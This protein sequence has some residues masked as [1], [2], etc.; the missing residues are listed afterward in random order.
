MGSLRV[1]VSSTAFDLEAER[2]AVKAALER[3]RGTEFSGMELFGSRDEDARTA[4]LEEVDDSHLYVGIIGGRYGSGI[5]R[6]EYD[7]ARERGL[8]CLLYLQNDA[9]IKLRDDDAAKARSREEWIAAITD[10]FNGHLVPRFSSAD[11]LA[12]MVAADVHNWLFRTLV[13]ETKTAA[14]AGATAALR[15]LLV[16]TNNAAALRAALLADGVA[17]GDDLL[18][19]L[20]AL[21]PGTV[22]QLLAGIRDLP[23][24]YAARIENF[25]N[26]YIGT[27]EQPVP[28]GG[29]ADV[30]EELDA[31]LDRDPAHPYLLIAAEAGRGK[32]AALVHWTRRRL[33]EPGLEVVFV[34]VSIRFRT[35]L[36][37]VFFPAL[38]A[39]LARAHGDEV[40]TDMNLPAEVWRGMV[41]DYLREPLPDGRMLV[42]V[43]DG[44]DEAADWEAGADLFP[45]RAPAG[46]RIVVSARL[47]ADL[48]SDAA[49][50]DQLGWDTHST[51]T[52]ALRALT[53]EGVGDVMNGMG[54]P[55]ADLGE[56]IVAA[57]YRLSEGDPLLIRLYVAELW[58]RGDEAGRLK[59]EDLPAIDPGL[60]GFFDRWWR[61]QKKLWGDASP[62]KERGVRTVLNL[63]V[64]AFGPLRREDILAL[65]P[66]ESE[67]T[68]WTL[69]D[70]IEPVRRF[71]IEGSSGLVFSH[72][73][74]GQYLGK[75]LTAGGAPGYG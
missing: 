47:T 43:L 53:P 26:E 20:L 13:R 54:C 25:L 6:D 2:K 61:E 72:P 34:P 8:D 37:G 31:W 57:L 74:F 64:A 65:A 38:A 33:G 1:F 67:L 3:M 70:A 51:Q 9:A 36:S 18:D 39:R 73:R 7:R 21:S 30:F 52:L 46:V 27:A 60:E 40:P 69:D 12:T 29:R 11:E 56:T 55:L 14:S 35:N 19:S 50:L 22:A 24:D 32:T 59:P 75:E 42:V 15:A 48:P 28:F 71:I 62:L 63:L 58:S 41:A 16:Q 44:L 49:W 4:S 45:R 68:T 10:S 23:T 17:V 5:T 66:A